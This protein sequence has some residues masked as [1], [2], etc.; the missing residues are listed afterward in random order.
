MLASAELVEDRHGR[1][2]GRRLPMAVNPWDPQEPDDPPLPL[3]QRTGGVHVL[4]GR[5]SDAVETALEDTVDAGFAVVA[6]AIAL[7]R[8]AVEVGRA[9]P[10]A[11]R[12]RL[13]VVVGR[14]TVRAG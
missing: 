3:P 5:A 13:P 1:G 12:R 8:Y 14:G 11:A 10:Q 6:V 4:P 9:A 2:R 7:G